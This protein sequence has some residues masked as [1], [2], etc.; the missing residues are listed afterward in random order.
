M[1]DVVIR[2]LRFSA[3][4][5]A[6]RAFLETV[7]L[8]ARIESERGGWAVMLAG[9]GMIALHD[10]A[11]SS[12]GGRPGQTVLVF[13]AENLDAL[14]AELESAGYTDV[15]IWD[16]AYGRV[17]SAI[18]PSGPKLQVD[19][20]PDDL[21]GYRLNETRP[22][23][24]WTVT[25]HLS[26]AGGSGWRQILDLLETKQTVY[27]G[28]GEEYAVRMD[29]STTEDLDAVLRRLTSAGYQASRN[30]DT[31]EVVDPDGQAL[32]VHG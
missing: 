23:E 16:E 9:Q 7:G 22:D 25:P 31:L 19:E 2:P 21:Y 30:A 20:R 13:E 14:K 8:T 4:V 3:D 27:F 18:A 11:T 12:T 26:G 6:M 15:S 24:R 32:V 5:D 1:T 17:L 29:L 10:A 28:A